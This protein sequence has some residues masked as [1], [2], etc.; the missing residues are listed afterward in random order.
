MKR[1]SIFICYAIIIG[2]SSAEI[3]VGFLNNYNSI[4]NTAGGSDRAFFL[5]MAS[6]IY[7]V[8]TL[9]GMQKKV[10]F[11]SDAA[12]EEQ[13][14]SQS[15]ISQYFIAP[16]ILQDDISNK[17]VIAFVVGPENKEKLRS[18]YKTLFNSNTGLTLYERCN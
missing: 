14:S 5:G 7:E 16:T 8:R 10:S 2:L 9:I 12:D 15:D 3:V 13:R 4:Q 1:I 18:V 6:S 17:Y 11:L